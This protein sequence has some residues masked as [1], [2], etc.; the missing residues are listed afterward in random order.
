MSFPNID[1]GRSVIDSGGDVVQ[2]YG[3]YATK[4]PASTGQSREYN[5]EFWP[6]GNRFAAGHR[7][8]LY[9]VGTSAFMLPPA[10]GVNLISTGATT[11]S[12]LLVPLIPDRHG[13][14]TVPAGP[15]GGSCAVTS[16]LAFHINPVPHGRVVQV[17]AYING[18]RVL[19][20]RGRD[21]RRISLLLPPGRRRIVKVI[22]INNEGGR[23]VT[24]RTFF[25][26]SR[27]RVK[28]TPYR[29]GKGAHRAHK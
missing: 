17:V 25:R 9:L 3:D 18:H 11:P 1:R 16:Q 10:P 21:L 7:L 12:R 5:V 26:C 29:H 2:P 24:L 6:I 4:T 22:S 28:G 13:S 19:V 27:T 8:R 14:V 23:V 20:R 15:S